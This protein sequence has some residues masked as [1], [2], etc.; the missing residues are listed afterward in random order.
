MGLILMYD[1][2]IAKL[3]DS[4]VYGFYYAGEDGVCL[5]VY[6][7]GRW[8]RAMSLAVDAKPWFSVSRI[9]QDFHVLYQDREGRNK[10][11]FRHDDGDRQTAPPAILDDDNII[12]VYHLLT[13]GQ[14]WRLVY[15]TDT[16]EGRRVVSRAAVNG[17][18]GAR[19][20]IGSHQPGTG[21]A[22][23]RIQQVI[24]DHY[25]LFS[26]EKQA[27]GVIAMGY[28]ELK[29]GKTGDFHPVHIAAAAAAGSSFITTDDAIHFLYIVRG[30][31]SS[32]LVY[33]KRQATGLTA[34][35]SVYEGTRMDECLLFIAH[36]RLYACYLSAG[37]MYICE[38]DNDGQSFRRPQRY[39]G[40]FCESPVKA[41]YLPD[42]APN[43]S[44]LAA[45]EVWV[46]SH[47]PWDVQLIPDIYEDFY[48]LP[49]GTVHAPAPAPVSQVPQTTQP[50]PLPTRQQEQNIDPYVDEDMAFF[51]NQGTEML[52]K[53]VQT[54]QTVIERLYREKEELEKRLAALRGN[55]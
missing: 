28:R 41:A 45:R 22:N 43:E 15:E 6:E 40:K 17:R 3:T 34:A 38:S 9:S 21:F 12:G 27:D 2:F 20:E 24:D 25:I 5:R 14:D 18:W 32:R 11:A 44:E 48:P 36:D 29:A 23:I 50:K 52:K 13:S 54:Q 8:G 39:R 42:T 47:N 53:E 1:A 49:Q 31:F 35:V 10:H 51:N 4:K 37:A 33:R 46:D 30:V 16:E 55:L 7:N 26:Q 19:E